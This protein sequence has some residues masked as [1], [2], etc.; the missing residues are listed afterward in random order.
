M[1]QIPFWLK[2]QLKNAFIRRDIVKIKELNER[3]FAINV[4]SQPEIYF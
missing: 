1:N 3:L 4:K 2:S